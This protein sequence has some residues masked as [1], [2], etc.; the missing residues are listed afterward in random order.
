MKYKKKFIKKGLGKINIKLI[1][2][3]FFNQKLI[4]FFDVFSEL[5]VKNIINKNINDNIR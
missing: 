3:N 4:N 2:F 1:S 5:K